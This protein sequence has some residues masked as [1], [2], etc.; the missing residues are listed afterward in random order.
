VKKKSII[1]V[2]AIGLVLCVAAV[3]LYHVTNTVDEV[4]YVLP[5]GFHGRFWMYEDPNG[6]RLRPV[7]GRITIR[8]PP[9]GLVKVHDT[10]FLEQWHITTG[11]DYSGRKMVDDLNEVSPKFGI[12]VFELESGVTRMWGREFRWES[13]FVGT[14][15]EFSAVRKSGDIAAFDELRARLGAESGAPVRR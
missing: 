10:W 1:I 9:D 6:G 3:L 7:N 8:V 5:A 15:A 2:L 4:H 12:A 13:C 11:A 14:P